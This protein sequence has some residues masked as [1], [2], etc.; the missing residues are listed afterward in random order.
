MAEESDENNHTHELVLEG[1]EWDEN[2]GVVKESLR[3][4]ICYQKSERTIEKVW[5]VE[6]YIRGRR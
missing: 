1:F 3:C 2:T 6:E 5:S 4:K